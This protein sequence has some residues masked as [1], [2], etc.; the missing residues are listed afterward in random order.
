VVGPAGAQGRGRLVDSQKR[1]AKDGLLRTTPRTDIVLHLT[2]LGGPVFALNP[3][4]IE[5]AEATPDTVVTLVNG[6][7]FVIRESLE[8]LSTLIRDYRA[9]V[10]AQAQLLSDPNRD[11]RPGVPPVA[12]VVPLHRGEH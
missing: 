3:D 6:S 12:S 8:E 5:R 1:E 9:T 10:I 2:R 4:L 7:H 11:S